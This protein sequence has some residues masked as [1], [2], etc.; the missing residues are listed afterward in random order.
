MVDLGPNLKV[1]ACGCVVANRFYDY[2]VLKL[3]FI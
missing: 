2:I 1:V 3:M